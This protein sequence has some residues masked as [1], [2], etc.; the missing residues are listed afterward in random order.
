MQLNITRIGL[1][2][3]NVYLVEWDEGQ[4]L[5]DAGMRWDAG[6]ILRHPSLATDRLLMILLTHAHIDHFGAAAGI[7][8]AAGTP[9]AIHHAD[10]GAL[11]LG[12]SPLG[13]PRGL[14]RF[15][16]FAAKL[17]ERVQP[18]EPCEPD[19]LLEEGDLLNLPGISAR[20]LHTPGHTYG[21]STFLFEGR[22]AFVGDLLSS[23][24][25]AHVQRYLAQ[26]WAV[27][28]DSV[29]RVQ[30]ANPEWVY[31]GHGELPIEGA[32]FSGLGRTGPQARRC[33]NPTM[34]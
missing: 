19:L 28:Y 14:G 15:L 30:A 5:V 31:P 21:S 9:V 13:Q 16:V 10:A 25:E 23:T 1:R 24:G 11:R 6:A 3:S 8:R 20:V 18:P 33:M 32:G 12:R 7:R 34:L 29:R 4:V 26:D 22:H 27:L 2:F 17:L